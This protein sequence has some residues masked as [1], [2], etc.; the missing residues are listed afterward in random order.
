[1][2]DILGF[3]NP[4]ET[5]KGSIIAFNAAPRSDQTI[6]NQKLAALGIPQPAAMRITGSAGLAGLGKDIPD[7]ARI[8]NT[9]SLTI[10]PLAKDLIPSGKPF[11]I[12]IGPK[13]LQGAVALEKFGITSLGPSTQTEDPLQTGASVGSVRIGSP[14]DR[15]EPVCRVQDRRGHIHRPFEACSIIE[16][17][18]RLRLQGSELPLPVYCGGCDTGNT[19][20]EIQNARRAVDA[21]RNV[22]KERLGAFESVGRIKSFPG[23]CPL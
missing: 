7:A 14:A 20:N 12:E 6:V 23:S 19:D 11:Q 22:K 8:E 15:G 21:S 18:H 16:G 1:M 9:I 17:S 13:T 5:D 10:E 2:A 4:R 3:N